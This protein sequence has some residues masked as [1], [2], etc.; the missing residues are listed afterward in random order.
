MDRVAP[1]SQVSAPASCESEPIRIPGSI[2]PH[3][4][5]LAVDPDRLDVVQLA[6][7]TSTL[8]GRAHADLLG[9]SLKSWLDPAATHRLERL[10]AEDQLLPRSLFVFEASVEERHLDVAAHLSD[11]L[12]VLEFERRGTGHDGVT[13]V[14]S[15]LSRLETSQDLQ[16]LLDSIASEVRRVTGF[17]RVMVYRFREDDSGHVVAE[18]RESA[19]VDS[20]L[21]LH[22]PASDIPAQARDLYRRCWIR[23]IPDRAYAA[24][25]L[26]P[27]DNPK[28]GAPLDLG[29]SSLRSVSPLHLEY[30]ANMGVCASMSLSIVIGDRLWGLVACHAARPLHLDAH[31]RGALELFAN[32]ASLQIHAHIQIDQNNQRTTARKTLGEIALSMS[33]SGVRQGLLRDLPKLLGF[34]PAA[35]VAVRI[36]GM[37]SVFGRAPDD[38]QIAGIADWLNDSMTG[39][40]QAVNRLGEVYPAAGAFRDR[41]SGLLALSVSRNPGDYV[42]WFL[43][44]HAEMINWAGDPKKAAEPSDSGDRLMP[45]KSFEAWKELEKG[46]SRPWT[47]T[48]IEAA[49][50]LRVSIVEIVLNQAIQERAAANERHDLLVAELEHRVKNTLATIQAMVR[51]SARSAVDL[52][53]YTKAIERRLISM[54]QAH[55][56]MT[57]NRWSGA[58]IRALVEQEIV[59]YRPAPDPAVAIEGEDVTLGPRASIS[60]SLALHELTT[61][62]VKYGCLSVAE[63]RLSVSWRVT[64]RDGESWL[65]IEWIERDGPPV[66]APSRKGFGCILLERIFATDVDGRVSLAFEPSGVRCV[67]EIPF[68][69][70]VSDEIPDRAGPATGAPLAKARA[71]NLTEVTVLMIGDNALVAAEM[72]ETLAAKG[73]RILGPFSRLGDGAAV[74]AESAYDVVLLDVDI[75][76][77]PIW[78]VA[79]MIRQRGIPIVLTTGYSNSDLFP[80]EFAETPVVPKP[81]NSTQLVRTIEAA[82]RPER[83]RLH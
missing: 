12:V 79:H 23:S 53:G 76:G 36:G 80:R 27:P 63:G 62:S 15:M 64:A 50:A 37:N 70:V 20:F 7:D 11:G 75:G 25:P 73:A 13:A 24:M 83:G 29:F 19:D 16:S 48:E 65:E 32:L 69:H 17:D 57:D 9:H 31:L 44:E 61:N 26:L 2:Q 55:S 60:L 10:L 3:G 59:A 56:I 72:A 21:D 47:V 1:N 77:M 74:A 40:I 8:L 81:Y 38:R 34:I 41:A 30:L 66:R 18:S 78:P 43:P 28:T 22:Y 5:L 58:S 35:G 52:V 39:T 67:L 49:A 46:R 45:R 4:V 42:M 54:A 68:A 33:Q 14:K 71:A 51:S 6:G 82:A